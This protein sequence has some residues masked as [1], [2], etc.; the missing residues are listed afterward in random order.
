MLFV[1]KFQS[2]NLWTLFL[3]SL[4]IHTK[5]VLRMANEIEVERLEIVD[6]VCL[7]QC[8]NENDCFLKAQ[9]SNL[10]FKGL[11]LLMLRS[12][13]CLVQNSYERY[14]SHQ[15]S[16]CRRGRFRGTFVLS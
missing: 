3:G 13:I 5:F 7:G 11:Y 2:Q 14:L 4:M 12:Y 16:H 6:V 9:V 10:N 15:I 8:R 1:I